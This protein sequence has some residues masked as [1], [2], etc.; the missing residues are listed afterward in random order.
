ME[1]ADRTRKASAGKDS[2]GLARRGGRGWYSVSMTITPRFDLF[3]CDGPHEASRP[4]GDDDYL[5]EVAR[6][7]KPLQPTAVFATYW[8]FAAAR[9]QVFYRRLLNQA[10]PWT[11]DPILRDHRFTNAYRAS[12]RV[13]QYLIRQILD[14]A[15]AGGVYDV[16]DTL[17][18]ILLFKLFNRVDTWELLERSVGRLD[19]RNYSFERYDG[20]ARTLPAQS[21]PP[22]PARRHAP[23]PTR[24]T[25]GRTAGRV[26]RTGI[27]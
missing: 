24:R 14:P 18:R 15:T 4:T 27:P 21:A 25:S 20:T 12:D 3:A 23:L 2:A 17:F 7:W 1:R 6:D 22:S 8:Y 11:T 10:P 26:R 16:R 5:N 19:W 9:Q 13:S